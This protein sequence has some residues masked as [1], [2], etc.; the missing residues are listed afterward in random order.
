[1]F[2]AIMLIIGL[3]MTILFLATI[4]LTLATIFHILKRIETVP[5]KDDPFIFDK[6]VLLLPIGQSGIPNT[7]EYN[8]RFMPK[9]Y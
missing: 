1:M 9:A 3:P 2:G 8:D 4:W 7:S 5:L 6:T